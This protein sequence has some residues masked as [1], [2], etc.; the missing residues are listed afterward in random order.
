MP[1]VDNTER[2]SKGNNLLHW[3][4]SG[5]LFVIFFGGGIIEPI[6][7]RC[8]CSGSIS[9]CQ[10]NLKNI[11]TALDMYASDNTGHYPEKLGNLAPDYLREIPTCP[12][13]K[14]DSYSPSYEVY[15]DPDPKNSIFTIYCS[16]YNHIWNHTHQTR[17]FGL[18]KVR[19]RLD[20]P[21]NYPKY[22]SIYGSI[23]EPG[24]EASLRKRTPELTLK[25]SDKKKLDNEASPQHDN[26]KKPE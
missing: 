4:I 10:S 14:L 22:S 24:A 8:R 19:Q 18:I 9:T 25:P 2:K 13:A 3:C 5:F 12:E 21:P 23:W 20:L 15:F 6:L 16:G 11:A 17:F 1:V 7:T 26:E